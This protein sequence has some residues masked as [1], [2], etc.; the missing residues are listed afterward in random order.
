MNRRL[1]LASFAREADVIR[2]VR[3]IRGMGCRVV[4]VYTPYPVHGLDEAMGL[5]PSRLP[6][7]CFGLGALGAVSAFFFQSW[8]AT[9][10]WPLHIGG[11]P[12]FAWP[13]FIPITFELM[14]LFAG[15]GTVGAL[16]VSRGL[17]PWKT[18][19]LPLPGATDDRFVVAVDREDA[20]FDA[21]A[22]TELCRGCG[23]L[24]IDARAEAAS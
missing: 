23:V 17:L 18:P 19:L 7:V 9:I 5:T 15:V 1:F 3:G 20:L 24:E 12:L 8:V 16:L 2:A 4:D 11:K 22:I 14:V 6:V 21:E 13:S 10:D